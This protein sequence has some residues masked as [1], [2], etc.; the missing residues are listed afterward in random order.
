MHVSTAST[1][2]QSTNNSF[3]HKT[4]SIGNI[5]TNNKKELLCTRNSCFQIRIKNQNLQNRPSQTSLLLN[6][7]GLLLQSDLS[8]RLGLLNL[9]NGVLQDLVALMALICKTISAPLPSKSNNTYNKMYTRGNRN[10]TIQFQH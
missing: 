9:L 3:H 2:S 6:V 1:Y 8:Q 10:F 4:Q 5:Q 7:K